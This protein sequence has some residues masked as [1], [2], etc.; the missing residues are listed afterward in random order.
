M[1][2]IT[3]H[4]ILAGTFA[5][6]AA[7]GGSGSS[8][9]ATP[10]PSPG[11]TNPCA[12]ITVEAPVTAGVST[13]EEVA[14]AE[15]KRDAEFCGYSPWNVL[16]AVWKHR[17]AQD[18]G[19]T[20]PIV[21][22]PA[23]EDIGD[24]SVIQDEGDIML[25]ANRFDL[26]AAG[27]S[28]VRNPTGGYDVR[29]GVATFRQQ[30]GR[31][32][33]LGD[34][35]TESV[36]LASPAS[37]YGQVFASAFVNSD[38]NVTFG[39]GDNASTERSVSRFLVGPP[40]IAAFFADL[41][42]SAGGGIF[43]D[44]QADAFTVTWCN[45][46]GYDDSRRVTAQVV[47]QSNG[48]V[49]LKFADTT[50]LIDAVV[51]LSPGAANVFA[52]VDFSQASTATIDGGAAAVGE[53]FAEEPDIDLAALGQKFYLTHPDDF[54]QLVVWTDRTLVAGNTFAYEITVANAI[55]GIGLT[56][57]DASRVFGS[58]GRLSS[59]AFMDEIG[60]YPDDPSVR[61]VGENSTLG[62]IGHE[63][64]HRWL[65]GLKFRGEGGA[66]SGAWL[67]RDDVHW[68]FFMDS[69]ASFVEGNDIQDLG[70]GAF[71]TGA[72]V[73]RYSALDQYA[74]GLRTEAEVPP[75]FYVESPTN[76]VPGRNRESAP[77]VGVTFNGTRRDVLIQD[78]V[79]ALGPRQPSPADSPRLQRQAFVYV[80]S[81]GTTVDRNSV[82]KIDR[83]RREWEPFFL[84]ATD[85]RMRVET[86]LRP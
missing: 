71:R 28:F 73:E 33:S 52:A 45:V 32:L 51:G 30:L 59:V 66:T 48:Q 8:T 18:R 74:M 79:D 1:Q 84:T 21:P 82:A 61:F 13:P 75:V 24:I 40:R 2:R 85:G 11:Q 26:K 44:S 14:A 31:R 7:C 62:L 47:V 6:A 23:S 42:P 67:G 27:L 5:L 12:S 77:R 81:R 15:A 36:T 86:R 80:L 41:D 34:D 19:W 53:R 35:A 38:G 70:G 17:A 76:V 63:S 54:D 68:S 55:R 46:P 16:D 22:V 58:G 49:D 83:Y 9:P 39:Q 4:A 37:L 43:V 64:G 25:P 56:A 57:F 69:D 20:R 78:V 50:T 72:A 3:T 65:V 60:K 10:A 29:P